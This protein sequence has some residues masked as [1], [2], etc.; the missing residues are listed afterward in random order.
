LL[1]GVIELVRLIVTVFR[2]TATGVVEV[3]VA[4]E[5]SEPE[6]V[7][8]LVFEPAGPVNTIEMAV[9]KGVAG[10]TNLK[11]LPAQHETTLRG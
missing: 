6:L 7:K 10:S 8:V 2:P 3:R 4:V 5:V 11:T 9:P 1:A